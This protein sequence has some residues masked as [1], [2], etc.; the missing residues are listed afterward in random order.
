MIIETF[1][2]SA[3][4]NDVLKAPSRLAAIPTNGTLTLECSSTHADGTNGWSL[5]IRDAEGDVPIRNCAVPYNGY[6][7][8]DDLL[9]G[10]TEWLIS[11]PVL[12]GQHIGVDAVLSGSARLFIRAPRS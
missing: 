11:I 10:S 7:D 6:S 1:Q 3:T 4:D 2:L 12:Q 5:S 8:T 9:H